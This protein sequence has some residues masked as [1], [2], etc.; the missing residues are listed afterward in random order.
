M[1]NLPS[2]QTILATPME[3]N[4]ANAG[5]IG[6]YLFKL[7]ETCWM[8]EESFSGKRPFGNSS[9]KGE[10]ASA[11]I[12]NKHLDGEL[13]E[14]GYI[15]DYDDSQ[16]TVIMDSVFELL[17]KADYSSFAL[18]PEP[19]DHYLFSFDRDGFLVDSVDNPFSKS[20]AEDELKYRNGGLNPFR[21]KAV[22]IPS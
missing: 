4:D 17:A 22:H 16:F 11:L 13:D 15:K 7:T 14:D 2:P 21:W 3:E 6:Q 1:S 8:E 10:V 9:W 20:E 5:T 18:P 12:L 19:K